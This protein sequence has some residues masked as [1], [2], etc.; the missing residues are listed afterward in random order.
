M[1]NHRLVSYAI[2][3]FDHRLDFLNYRAV[4]S[5][6]TRL[7][8]SPALF[9]FF[10]KCAARASAIQ[11]QVDLSGNHSVLITGPDNLI[12]G[13]SEPPLRLAPLLLG[14]G[15]DRPGPAVM[16]AFSFCWKTTCPAAP[17]ITP[18]R[19]CATFSGAVACCPSFARMRHRIPGASN[20]SPYILVF[21]LIR[22]AYRYRMY[23][24]SRKTGFP[25]VMAHFSAPN[26]LDVDN[27]KAAM[28]KYDA[29]MFSIW[30]SHRP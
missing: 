16:N 17:F 1:A 13:C 22:I 6:S 26:Y 10:C 15:A 18:V 20:P 11:P 23:R 14:K 7:V 25:S 29:N 19:P 9:F 8:P 21:R 30:Q 3:H 4:S 28:V 27:N 12:A 2:S 5:E 24:K